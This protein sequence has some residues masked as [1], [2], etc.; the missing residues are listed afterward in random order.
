M[1]AWMDEQTDMQTDKRTDEERADGHSIRQTI[2]YFQ[3]LV[4]H[5]TYS[6]EN[7]LDN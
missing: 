3:K 5:G 2:N 1:D 6:V 4:L 7:E